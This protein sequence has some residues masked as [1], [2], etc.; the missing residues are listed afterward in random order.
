MKRKTLFLSLLALVLIVCAMVQPALAY[1]TANTQADG[2]IPLNFGYET[3]I[4]EGYEDFVKTVTIQNTGV[5]SRTSRSCR[6][7]RKSAIFSRPLKMV[8]VFSGTPATKPIS[9]STASRAAR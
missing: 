8:R 9:R 3:K 5:P 2:K 1:F 4:E 6:T 7:K